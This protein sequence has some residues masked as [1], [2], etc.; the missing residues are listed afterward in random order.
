[1]GLL[2]RLALDLN[3]SLD[4][5]EVLQRVMDEVITLTRAERGFVMLIEGQHPGSVSQSVTTITPGMQVSIARGIDAS[6]IISNEFQVSR[7]IIDSVLTSCQPLL[8]SDAQSDNRFTGHQSVIMYKLRS[9]LCVPLKV[10]EQ[11]RGIIYVD[12]RIQAGIFTPADMELLT[13]IAANAAIAIENARLYKVAVE[14]GR[15]EQ[16]LQVARNV[17]ASLLPNRTPQF[18]GWEIAARWL[19]ARQVAGDYYDFIPLANA[20]NSRLGIVI[21]DVT[22]KGMPAALFMAFTRSTLRAS[23]STIESPVEAIAH[24][25]ALVS[26]DSYKSMFVTLFYAAL[27]PASGNLTYINAGHNPPYLV[28]PAQPQPLSRLKRT[29]IPLGI[30]DSMTYTQE[31]VA[32][33]PGEMLICYTDGATDA[34]NPAG[35]DFG[36]ERFEQVILA[37]QAGSADSMLHAIETALLAFI[38]GGVPFDDITLVILKRL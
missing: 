14:K 33:Q 24:A 27:D 32:L 4:L 25:N 22:D 35:E 7:S 5:D 2:V 6:T 1:M 20:D 36:N 38:G 28:K 16:E 11:L 29:G 30:D 10:K 8:T 12:S 15:M 18:A 21:A 37:N 26:A 23:L 3:S 13:I 19:P 9:I 34:L 17:Q 31:M